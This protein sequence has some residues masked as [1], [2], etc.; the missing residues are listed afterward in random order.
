MNETAD[1]FE[2][3]EKGF[4][5]LIYDDPFNKRIRVDDFY[6]KTQSV[7]Q[8]AE[9][10]MKEKKR[11]KLIFK[12]REEQFNEFIEGGYTCEAMIDDYFL[13]SK[14]YFFTKYFEQKRMD[15]E[16]WITEDQM[17]TSINGMAV[18]TDTIVPPTDYQLKKIDETDAEKLALL[19]RTV[20]QIY[21][22]PLHDLNYIKETIKDGTI[23][24]A[25][26]CHGTIV[27][28]ASAEINRKYR[29]A[30]LTD[31]A[32]LT[33]HRKHGLM[34]ILLHKLE[35]ELFDQGIYCTYSIARSLSFGMNAVLHQLGY[36]YRG[37]L[38]NNV[39]IYDKLENMNVWVKNLAK[40]PIIRQ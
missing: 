29:N 34:K 5:L 26:Y 10:L 27:S 13:G 39:F 2:V 15:N 12:V 17:L 14:M 36:I 28:A 7:I 8:H 40:E 20:F 9:Q 21:P 18:S 6:G 33:E 16:H 3:N 23:Y 1:S 11:E 25:F 30:E 31:C 37:R 35:M 4:S 24:Y 22:T 32:T 19:Y 38:K